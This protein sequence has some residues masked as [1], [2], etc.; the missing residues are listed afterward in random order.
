M[1]SMES[2]FVP[3][4]SNSAGKSR[5][6]TPLYF[7]NSQIRNFYSVSSR[8]DQKSRQDKK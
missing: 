2:F 7:H 3:E 1:L 5:L 8:N 6:R 4:M